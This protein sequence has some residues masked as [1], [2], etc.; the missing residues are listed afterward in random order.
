MCCKLCLC[1]HFFCSGT[2]CGR[3]GTLLTRPAALQIKPTNSIKP[4]I[5]LKLAILEI[6]CAFSMQFESDGAWAY[7]LR[8]GAVTV[9]DVTFLFESGCFYRAFHSGCSE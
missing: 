3:H 2:Y 1:V 5:R 6:S 8:P 7:H 9:S 4:P